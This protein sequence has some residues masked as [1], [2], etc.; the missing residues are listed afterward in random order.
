MA[1]LDNVAS[2]AAEAPDAATS[3]TGGKVVDGVRYL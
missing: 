3:N 2:N 1:M